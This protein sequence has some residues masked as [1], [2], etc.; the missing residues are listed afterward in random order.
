[1]VVL[2][3]CG[4]LGVW[5]V[6]FGFYFV[7]VDWLFA[8]TVCWFVVFLFG[9]VYLLGFWLDGFDF[10]GCLGWVDLRVVVWFTEGMNCF[11]VGFGLLI[12]WLLIVRLRGF[13]LLNVGEFG[14]ELGGFGLWVCWVWVLFACET[15]W[16]CWY[17]GFVGVLWVVLGV[18]LVLFWIGFRLWFVT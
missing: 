11:G 17:C 4:R 3:V 14:F 15:V 18:G 9:F 5:V 10:G 8:F 1:M 16:W 2:L 13:L 7:L 6:G 12:V